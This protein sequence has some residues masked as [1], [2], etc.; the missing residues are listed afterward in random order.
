MT[1]DTLRCADGVWDAVCMGATLEPF[2]TPD[3]PSVLGEIRS[4]QKAQGRLAA[5]SL[6]REGRERLWSLRCCKWLHRRLPRYVTCR[7][8]YLERLVRKARCRIEK[9]REVTTGGPFPM[10]TVIARR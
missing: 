5:I 4:V 10:K 8:I 1:R 2:D 3:I 7:P 6:S 9:T